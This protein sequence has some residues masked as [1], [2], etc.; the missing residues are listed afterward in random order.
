[1]GENGTAPWFADSVKLIQDI[2]EET[3]PKYYTTEY[4]RN[5]YKYSE[6]Q[7]DD[8][9][10]V[11]KWIKLPQVSNLNNNFKELKQINILLTNY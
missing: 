4:P 5:L 8:Y 2:V 1:M 7:R 3:L 11:Q 10:E 6:S 9:H